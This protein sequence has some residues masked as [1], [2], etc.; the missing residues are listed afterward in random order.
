MSLASQAGF[1]GDVNPQ[2]ALWATDIPP[3]LRASPANI[4]GHPTTKYT[5]KPI[6]DTPKCVVM[7]H[8]YEN[9]GAKH[10]ARP[11]VGS[12]VKMSAGY[13]THPLTR[14]VLTSLLLLRVLADRF[15]N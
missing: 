6:H 13:L 9:E 11:P 14:M 2:L 5:S 12:L 8:P 3:A 4:R 7:Y 15:A 10:Q 1:N